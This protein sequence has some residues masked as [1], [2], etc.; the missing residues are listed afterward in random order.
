[1]DQK[2]ILKM[3]INNKY[4]QKKTCLQRKLKNI[5]MSKNHFIQIKY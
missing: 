5:L 1:M 3:H 2:K 4:K